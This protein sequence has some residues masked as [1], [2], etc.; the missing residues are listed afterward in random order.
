MHY[1][2]TIATT[3]TLLASTVLAQ[4]PSNFTPSSSAKLDL[5]FGSN[6]TITPGQQ[7]GIN[8][9][10]QQPSVGAETALNG[11]YILFIV[12]PDAP[13]PTNASVSQ[14]LHWLQPGLRFAS[15]RNTT[16]NA[17]SPYPATI[18]AS[19]TGT[20][21]YVRPQPPPTSPA[22]RYIALLYAQPSN[23][24]VPAAFQSFSATNRTKFNVS[25]FAAQARLGNVVA[26]NYFLVSN[27][28]T[29]TTGAG[30]ATSTRPGVAQSTGG[31]AV[32]QMS[33]AAVV[34]GA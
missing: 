2:T 32:M 33:L 16:A 21:P 9:P 12:D 3:V 25:M 1:L 8:V 27:M 28:T 6:T 30:N 34:V 19:A 26:A 14:Y 20:V 23:F 10:A 13:T 29:T 7:I 4:T 11:T 5:R 15:T 18:N 17:F 22:H 24:S 31:A